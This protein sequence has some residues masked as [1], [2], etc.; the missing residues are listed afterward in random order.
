MA[1][2]PVHDTSIRF[3]DRGGVVSRNPNGYDRVYRKAADG[4]GQKGPPVAEQ[5]N[6]VLFMYL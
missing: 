6:L 1:A 5:D 4:C 2:D 3:T